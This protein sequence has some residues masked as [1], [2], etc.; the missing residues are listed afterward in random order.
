MNID[1]PKPAGLCDSNVE[2]FAIKPFKVK[3]INGG[4]VYSFEDMPERI[5]D[6][7]SRKRKANKNAEYSLN[8]LGIKNE[9]ERDERFAYC[10]FGKLDNTPDIDLYTETI[11]AEF[12]ICS[13]RH[14]CPYPV[15]FCIQRVSTPSGI[16]LSPREVELIQ[17]IA[18]GF[19]Y[20]E[21]CQHMLIAEGTLI[22]YRSHVFYKL[23]AHKQSDVT[24][25]ALLNNL[26]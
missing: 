8:K 26:L 14:L 12:R 9:L 19:T 3:A 10:L 17:L 16:L 24:R 13:G 11:H 6:I 25:F 5:R 2:F 4:R 1:Y 23:E 20:K 15:R 18:Q 21:I 22:T 7:V